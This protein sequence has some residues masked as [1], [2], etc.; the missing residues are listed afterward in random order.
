M[1]QKSKKTKNTKFVE[2][3]AEPAKELDPLISRRT[4]IIVM[5]LL[6]VGVAI[7]LWLSAPEGV[8]WASHLAI[9]TVIVLSIWLAFAF[10]YTIS[11]WLRQR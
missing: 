7:L 3:S 10:I 8:G 11:R 1:G 5:I 6:S 2:Q 4:G 9:T